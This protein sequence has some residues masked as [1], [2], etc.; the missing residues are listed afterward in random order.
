MADDAAETIR[1]NRFL[2]QSGVA[3]RRGADALIAEGRVT[4]DGAVAQPGAQ[5]EPGAVVAVDGA[6][7]AAE[8]LVH[9]MLNKPI[10]YVTTVRDPEGRPT[11]MDLV[12]AVERVVPVGR[13]DAMTSGLLLLT[14]DGDLAHRLA[15]P[16]HGVPKTYRAIVRGLPGSAALRK[17]QQGVHLDDGRTQPAQ[18]AVLGTRS[19][20]AELELTIKEGRNRQV[21]RMCA[22]V[23][24]PVLE[25]E[26]VAY[27]PLQ[28]GRLGTGT[29]RALKPHEVE[30][31]RDAASGG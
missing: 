25:L 18:V 4:I 11:V 17:L 7:V 23:G 13:L 6:P 28:L 2:A 16:R 19:G 21:R 27:G 12:D 22:A 30:A 15:H 24:Y 20:G 31:L 29:C 8:R 9:L 1:L 5:V 14:N 26:R 3:S 10:G